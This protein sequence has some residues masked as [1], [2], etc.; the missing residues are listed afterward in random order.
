GRFPPGCADDQ[1]P[2]GSDSGG[3]A[4]GKFGSS[5]LPYILS[6]IEQENIGARWKYSSY[7]G[8]AD[9]ANSALVAN[10]NLSM[11][12]CPSST[13]PLWDA[14]PSGGSRLVAS[15]VGIAGSNSW[16]GYTESRTSNIT[17]TTGC[18]NSGIH[19]AG[20]VLFANSQIRITDITDGT[21][22]T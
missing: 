14:F 5:W 9:A 16:T 19:S 7:S 2:F 4:G 18:C 3:V 12:V 17:G 21:S 22:N 11:L 6:D 1:P 13:L 20:G 15:Y 10:V 8:R